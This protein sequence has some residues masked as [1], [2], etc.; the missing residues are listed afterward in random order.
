MKKT[1]LVFSRDQGSW[2]TGAPTGP[3]A[4]KQVACLLIFLASPIQEI[5]KNKCLGRCQFSEDA[6]CGLW[7]LERW[8]E[9]GS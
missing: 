3:P 9:C 5:I 7:H 1:P 2:L 8:P 4:G 6:D